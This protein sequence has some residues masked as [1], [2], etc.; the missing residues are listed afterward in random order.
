[1][2]L[3]TNNLLPVNSKFSEMR[4]LH[5]EAVAA[6]KD[7]CVDEIRLYVERELLKKE[8]AELKRQLNHTPLWRKVLRWVKK[9]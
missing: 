1:M 5:R 7:N 4:K 9:I 2:R 8:N 3:A 6:Y